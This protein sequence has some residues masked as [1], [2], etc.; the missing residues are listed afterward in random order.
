MATS[1]SL[2]EA[3][4]HLIVATLTAKAYKLAGRTEFRGLSISIETKKGQIR[5]GVGADGKPWSIKMPFAYGYIRG[6]VGA[7]GAHIDCFIGPNAE[8]EHVYV[9]HQH[10]ENSDTY[11]ED[12][13]M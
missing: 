2:S 10:K 4:M 3:K 11:D 13:Y 5:K 12:V 9:I 8:A 7:D 1:V 6:T